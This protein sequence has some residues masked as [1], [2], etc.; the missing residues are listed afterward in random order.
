M[1]ELYFLIHNLSKLAPAFDYRGHQ[2]VIDI[3]VE[4]WRQEQFITYDYHEQ[5]PR[6]IKR[7]IRIEIKN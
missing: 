6:M 7:V 1:K 5:K 4:K 2:R 3:I